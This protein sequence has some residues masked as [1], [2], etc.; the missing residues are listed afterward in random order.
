MEPTVAPAT[1]RAI[2]A[3]ASTRRLSIAL[4]I[5]ERRY[6]FGDVA[7]MWSRV[8]ACARDPWIGRKTAGLVPFG[9]FGVVEHLM[10]LS[11][12]LD[13]ALGRLIRF[14]PLVNQA[15]T[16]TTRTER[17]AI[18]ISLDSYD[19]RPIFPAYADFVLASINR[20]IDLATGGAGGI[21]Q[22]MHPSP[23]LVI[24]RSVARSRLP[25]ADEEM[26]EALEAVGERRLDAPKC[27]TELISD[28][29]A[30]QLSQGHVSLGAIARRIGNSKRTVQRRLIQEGTT[31]R[32]LLDETR[33]RIALRSL[34]EN[35]PS[36]CIADRVGFAEVR[37]FHR[38]FRR[39]TSSTPGDFRGK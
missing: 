29:I 21:A 24:D 5:E 33:R 14:Y 20:R 35:E 10:L 27:M 36:K 23:A 19:G 34:R 25:H 16:L 39:W 30:S 22:R 15:F 11:A 6:A 31:F 32:R 38:A 3:Y 1:V 13:D 8:A 18:V 12:T 37:S 2:A 26:C 17:D 4:D 28:A 9:A 7:G